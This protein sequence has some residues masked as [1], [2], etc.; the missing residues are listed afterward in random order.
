MSTIRI[1]AHVTKRHLTILL[2]IAISLSMLFFQGCA[3]KVPVTKTRII[4]VPEFTLNEKD[5][6]S[7]SQQGLRIKVKPIL[8]KDM[9]QYP[10]FTGKL[11]YSG[12]R[13]KRVYSY[14]YKRN[15]DQR[16]S[17]NGNINIPLFPLPAFEVSI[18]NNTKHVIKFSNATIAIE[19]SNGNLFDVL[20]KQDLPAYLQ[21]AIRINL[22]RSNIPSEVTITNK[23][24][25]YADQR[26]VK[27]IDNNFKV[28]PG[29]TT[30]GY[31][32]FNFGKY[33]VK[34][35]NVQL[36][37]LPI[38]VDKAGGVLETTSFSLVFDVKIHE[39]SEEYTT[40]EW[41]KAN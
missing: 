28:L 11:M 26:Q 8:G 34:D 2:S 35:F 31:L 25:L 33:T 39:K 40:Y 38:K 22:A 15:I 12:Y 36:Y 24:Q 4:K 23:N 18:T 16:E 30:K 37:V 9:E 13:T 5:S 29:R 32:A 7:L 27:L 10:Q 3:T 6:T 21:E 1:E 19:D 14:K 20:G 41:K 17:Y